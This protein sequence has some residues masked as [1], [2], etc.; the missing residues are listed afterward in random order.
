M[1]AA[2]AAVIFLVALALYALFSEGP[3]DH[4]PAPEKCP[5]A[6]CKNAEMVVIHF[7]RDVRCEGCCTVWRNT[8]RGEYIQPSRS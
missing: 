6:E 1:G 7:G 4:N 8:R 3:N 5:K 2:A